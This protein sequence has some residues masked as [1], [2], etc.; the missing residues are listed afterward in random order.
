MLVN[1]SAINPFC[2][3][4]FVWADGGGFRER[5]FPNWPSPDRVIDAFSLRPD[6]MLFSLISMGVD[7]WAG[8][9]SL[10]EDRSYV[11]LARD[12]RWQTNPFILQGGFLGGSSRAIESFA[13]DYRAHLLHQNAT[14]MFFGMDQ[15]NFSI[16]FA[17]TLG[18]SS[19]QRGRH[20]AIRTAETCGNNW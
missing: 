18:K 1:V 19:P 14:G 6:G 11:D 13:I 15:L 2:S 12:M 17:A 4:F 3:H 7:G 16:L 8:F 9:L 20:A 10:A 5:L